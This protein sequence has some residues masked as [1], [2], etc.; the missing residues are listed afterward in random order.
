MNFPPPSTIRRKPDSLISRLG[1]S[2]QAQIA[3]AGIE[4]A[5]P[6]KYRNKPL[7]VD[8]FRF[9]SQLEAKRYGELKLL[10]RAGK[11]SALSIHPKW[12]LDINNERISVY[13]ADFQYWIGTRKVVEDTKGVRTPEYRLKAKMMHAIYGITIAEITE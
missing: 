10:E 12:E 13:I 6:N 11:I 1:P 8:G 2:A 3:A 7:R 9:A 5:T 4:E